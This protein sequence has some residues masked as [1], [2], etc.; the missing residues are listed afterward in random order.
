MCSTLRWHVCGMLL[1]AACSLSSATATAAPDAAP[2]ANTLVVAMDDNYP[3]YV[4][5]D[6]SGT[7][8]GY[9][10][11]YWQLW[12]SKTGVTVKLQASDWDLAKQ[13]MQT[14][15]ATVI[16]TIFQTPE[17]EK[18]LDFT[19]PYA[20]IPVSI[21]THVGIGGIAS[22][23]HLTGFLVGV[24]AGDACVD[25]LNQA[26]IQTLQP[27]PN[28]EALVHA[29]IAGQVKIFCLDEPPANYLL[30]RDHAEGTFNKAF[31]LN[32][33]EFHR[34]V[35]KGDTQTMELLR[36]GFAATGNS[37]A[38]MAGRRFGAGTGA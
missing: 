11:D 34:A 19:P 38:S 36:R 3:P 32:V 33:G 20:Q 9:L 17:R 35:H 29:A 10:V 8:T 23:D 12:Q 6:S 31:Q 1:A 7:L 15:Q 24:K 28:Y 25:T 30:Y 27:Y 37:R 5:R 4:F 13:R 18:T 16:D 21:Y 22:L 14:R 26:G 2:A